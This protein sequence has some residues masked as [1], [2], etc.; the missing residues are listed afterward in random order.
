[1]S[2]IRFHDPKIVGIEKLLSFCVPEYNCRWLKSVL[3]PYQT[4]PAGFSPSLTYIL[5][6]QSDGTAAKIKTNNTIVFKYD[7]KQ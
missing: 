7:L 1:M 3:I 4:N 2:N 5:I 6:K